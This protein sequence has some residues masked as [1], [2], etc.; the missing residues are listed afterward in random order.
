MLG[1][2]LAS[3][4]SLETQDISG[5]PVA[6]ENIVT[7]TKQSVVNAEWIKSRLSTIPGVCVVGN[8]V[9]TER[10]GDLREAKGISGL[11]GFTPDN[12]E[13]VPTEPDGKNPEG[14]VQADQPTSLSLLP[15]GTKFKVGT[16]TNVKSEPNVVNLSST[17][18]EIEQHGGQ[19]LSHVTLGDNGGKEGLS[20]AER[21]CLEEIEKGSQLSPEEKE[22]LE[23]SRKEFQALEFQS[24]HN[25]KSNTLM[26][27]QE[28]ELMPER[29]REFEE[30][31]GPKEDLTRPVTPVILGKINKK[32]NLVTQIV[33]VQP[34]QVKTI[35]L[36]QAKQLNTQLAVSQ[37]INVANV[38]GLGGNLS[39]NIL[40]INNHIDPETL[41]ISPVLNEVQAGALLQTVNSNQTVYKP[42]SNTQVV[43]DSTP[44]VASVSIATDNSSNSTQILINTPQGQ[45]IFQ[46]NT[47]DINKAA[48]AIQ[49]LSLQ[50]GIVDKD[51]SGNVV[52]SGTVN[53]ITVEDGTFFQSNFIF[54]FS[55]VAGS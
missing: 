36:S 30:S 42:T 13:R 28:L 33:Q 24:L 12:T 54:C 8:G 7:L 50:G 17:L 41:T 20:E 55:A 39:G 32:D 11:F 52:N 1:E 51:L 19:H 45:Q 16:A 5:I 34:Q 9:V 23:N 6:Q 29:G 43:S 31:V 18:M 15:V 53:G 48:S 10:E 46:I 47:A 4:P 40:T 25:D 37:P 21:A 2:L 26:T 3:R 49:P 27:P 44:G 22:L 38:S 14:H 35:S